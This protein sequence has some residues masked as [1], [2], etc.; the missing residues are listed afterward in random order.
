VP[1]NTYTVIDNRV[2]L[3]PGR[4]DELDITERREECQWCVKSYPSCGSPRPYARCPIIDL[5]GDF[6]FVTRGDAGGGID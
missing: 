4:P 6:I 1:G 5:P 3:F 2:I